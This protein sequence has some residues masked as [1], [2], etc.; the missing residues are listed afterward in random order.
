MHGIPQRLSLAWQV[1]AYL[2]QA[3]AAGR[4]T[5]WLP[6]ERAL[7]ESL[8][9]SRP[10]LRRALVELQRE[11]IIRT[12]Q[13]SGNRILPRDLQPRDQ[14][15]SRDVGILAPVPLGRLRPNQAL[16]IDEL[17]AMLG[18]RGCHL[19]F[20]EGPQCNRSHPGPALDRLLRQHPF[21]CWV[22]LLAGV[23][24]Q[25]WFA[26]HEIPCVVAGYCH[27]G[28]DLPSCDLDHRATC[29]HAVGTLLAAGHRR[30]ALITHRH[31]L[32]GGI[33]SEAGFLEG[34]RLSRHTD[35]T[36]TLCRHTG[37]AASITRA[38]A[39][40][41]TPAARPTALVVPNSHCCLTVVSR[42]AR[43][44]WRVPEQ[45]S[46]ISRDDDPF[47]AFF[48][49]EMAR[50]VMSPRTFARSLLLQV[51]GQRQNGSGSSRRVVRLMPQFV[52]GASISS[53]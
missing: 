48:V 15:R 11:G 7:A 43:L 23:A 46:V 40:L 33:E 13:G 53:V 45:V 31:P 9:V 44:G 21:S 51:L 5:E 52:R 25:R 4:W 41:M 42:L 22:L 26:Q 29:R 37:T 38:M 47:L 39:R 16:W 3:L 19:H 27:A 50:Y 20:I 34:I 10:T 18:E 2:R 32:A 6:P 1:V 36:A 35:T 17:R 14:L 8:Q 49:P 30:L 24:W 12:A 28:I